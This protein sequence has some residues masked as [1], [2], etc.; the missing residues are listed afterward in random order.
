METLEMKSGGGAKKR[1][2]CEMLFFQQQ[3]Q[4]ITYLG[5]QLRPKLRLGGPAG[6]F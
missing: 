2:E 3:Q 6:R 1:P 4:K 5:A